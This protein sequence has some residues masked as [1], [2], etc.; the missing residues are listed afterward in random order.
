M[1]EAGLQRLLGPFLP[2]VLLGG[3][4]GGVVLVG[5][6]RPMTISVQSIKIGLNWT[7][8]CNVYKV[9]DITRLNISIRSI[10]TRPAGKPQIFYFN[11][12]LIQ[13]GH[14]RSTITSLA[15]LQLQPSINKC[16]MNPETTVVL[17]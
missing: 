1:S 12:I 3:G 16:C 2:T 15:N 6:I 4:S 9:S 10:N 14:E 5:I 17:S 13:P 11:R 7:E 8:L